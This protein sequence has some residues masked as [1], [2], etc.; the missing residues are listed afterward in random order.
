ME[1]FKRVRSKGESC[2]NF[3]RERFP[4]KFPR[5]DKADIGWWFLCSLA[6]GKI[7]CSVNGSGHQGSSSLL[8]V[9]HEF[10]RRQAER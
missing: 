8:I 4:G 10:Y 2:A 9:W 3:M 7:T 1:D 6:C 5:Y